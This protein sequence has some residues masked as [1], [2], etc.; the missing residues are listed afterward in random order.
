MPCGKEYC[1]GTPPAPPFFM[2]ARL[3]SKTAWYSAVNGGVPAGVQFGTPTR[4]HWP[5]RSGNFDSSRTR[6]LAEAIRA[7]VS[8]IAVSKRTSCMTVLPWCGAR[9][10]AAH[11]VVMGCLSAGAAVTTI[12]HLAG[13]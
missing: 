13:K 2:S 8:A 6:A 7:A 11:F 4:S 5:L 9:Y 10:G 12:H 1:D 3:A